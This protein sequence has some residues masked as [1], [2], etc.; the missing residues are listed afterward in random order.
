MAKVKFTKLELIEKRKKLERFQK[1]LPTLKMKQSLLQFEVLQENARIS[2]YREEYEKEKKKQLAQAKLLTDPFIQ[3]LKENIRVENIQV[4]MHNIAGID[5]PEFRDI[6]FHNAPTLSMYQ[7]IWLEDMTFI[8]REQKKMYQKVK[9]A[10]KK[11]D[12]LAQELRKITIRVNLF[13]KRL[14]PELQEDIL[15][16]RIFLGDQDLQ[17]I[18]SAKVAKMKFIQKKQEAFA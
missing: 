16:I 18:A 2:Q 15:K 7:P 12:I 17:A 1:Y 5:V 10:E 14:L 11:R 13:E 6:V 9:V 3:D 4:D 8:L